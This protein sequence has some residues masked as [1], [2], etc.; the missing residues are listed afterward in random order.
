MFSDVLEC[1][2]DLTASCSAPA[3]F[4]I[5]QKWLQEQHPSSK[6]VK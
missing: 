2:A 6:E 4:P 5:A 3:D 1:A